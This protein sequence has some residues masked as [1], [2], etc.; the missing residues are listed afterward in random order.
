[1]WDANLMLLESE[2]LRGDLRRRWSSW[3]KDIG[4][5]PWFPLFFY[6]PSCPFAQ[7]LHQLNDVRLNCTS[8]SP[9]SYTIVVPTFHLSI[10]PTFRPIFPWLIRGTVTVSFRSSLLLCS[11][12]TPFICSSISSSLRASVHHLEH[13][14]VH[15]FTF[16]CH[17]F[18]FFFTAKTSLH[19]SVSLS[20]IPP[21]FYISVSPIFRPFISSSPWSID[22]SFLH[23]IVQQ[24]ICRL[25]QKTY[26]ISLL[27]INFWTATSSRG[28]LMK[29]LASHKAR[30]NFC[31]VHKSRKSTHSARQSICDT[32]DIAK[33]SSVLLYSSPVVLLDWRRVPINLR[34]VFWCKK[35]WRAILQTTHVATYLKQ[36]IRRIL[37]HAMRHKGV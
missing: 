24:T 9:S 37:S 11:I 14:A 33:N 20:I 16:C 8:G 31:T 27:K 2:V 30:L 22:S 35:R 3:R 19:S 25:K 12:V 10:L 7:T 6:P 15:S 17:S 1:M 23:L 32:R 36:R 5:C 13:L 34:N 21:F 29:N 26:S 4:L 28:L 18:S